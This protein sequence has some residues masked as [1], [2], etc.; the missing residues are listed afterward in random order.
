MQKKLDF[1][2][3]LTS[4]SELTDASPRGE[5]REEAARFVTGALGRPST[6]LAPGDQEK[7]MDQEENFQDD[8]VVYKLRL[9]RGEFYQLL[10]RR[11]IKNGKPCGGIR[12][13]VH[14]AIRF[15]IAH[16]SRTQDAPEPDGPPPSS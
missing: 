16:T 14:G 8:H 2:A 4:S 1:L 5:G 13:M 11:G 10:A 9:T 15:Y 3:P 12:N 7:T 6:S